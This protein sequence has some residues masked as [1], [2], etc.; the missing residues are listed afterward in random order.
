VVIIRHSLT[1]SREAVCCRRLRLLSKWTL[2]PAH[3]V[4]TPQFNSWPPG[5]DRFFP[6]L[7]VVQIWHHYTSTWSTKGRRTFKVYV[8]KL[9]KTSKWGWSDDLFCRKWLYHQYCDS[10]STGMTSALT[11][12][13]TMSKNRH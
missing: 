9:M 10:W 6:T 3:T 8:S 1:G 7:P 11:D 2:P 12:A 13:A 5:S 4:L